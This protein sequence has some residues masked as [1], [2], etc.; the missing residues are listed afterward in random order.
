[1]KK[2]Q[3][4]ILVL[5]LTM[6]AATG[7][8]CGETKR[9]YSIV[10]CDFTNSVDSEQSIVNIK[11][12]AL[13]I[14][15]R[16]GKNTLLDYYII[17]KNT[18]SACVFRN[19]PLKEDSK[20]SERRMFKDSLRKQIDNLSKSLDFAST[21]ASEVYRREPNSCIIDCI[22]RSLRYFENYEPDP[23][24]PL[25]LYIL[26]DM[27]EC[28]TFSNKQKICL[29]P[30]N[31]VEKQ[32]VLIPNVTDSSLS[33]AKFGNVRVH[34]VIS[35]NKA[36]EENKAAFLDFWVAVFKRYNY[37]IRNKISVELPKVPE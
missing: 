36:L 22:E 12:N 14:L 4:V 33:F 13:R 18:N 34:I 10:F 23:S 25:E 16:D 7:W 17:N 32:L 20:P 30:N 5:M 3:P 19:S 28:C 26:S 2:N 8:K 21:K 37:D 24:T 6:L 31:D 29:E 11:R 9:A 35:T 15:E 27:L 1:M